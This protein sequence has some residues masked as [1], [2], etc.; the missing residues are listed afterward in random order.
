MKR[1]VIKGGPGSAV[2]LPQDRSMD[3]KVLSFHSEGGTV[4]GVCKR[5]SGQGPIVELAV[6]DTKGV[7]HRVGTSLVLCDT[8]YKQVDCIVAE[9][10]LRV[11]AWDAVVDMSWDGKTGMPVRRDPADAKSP[12]I[13]YQDVAIEGYLSTFAKT[14]PR[15]RDGD[16]VMPDAFKETLSAFK[17]NP[18][19]LIDHLNKVDHVAGSFEKI[20]VNE[21]GLAVRAKFSNA[22]GLVDVRFKV[23]EGHVRTLSMGGIFH[24]NED[25]H[26]IEKVVLYEGSVCPIPA[27]PDARFMVRSFT[28]ID[29]A[30]AAKSMQF[31]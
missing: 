25:G 4:Y 5:M 3:G 20:G 22:P 19:M 7:L 24:Y 31:K 21:Q 17:L 14:T 16:Y 29:A 10:Q 30:K 13:D 23:A 26:G 6:P 9:E 28:V 2:F 15:D 12:I 1:L 11:K 27:N 8:E 18:V